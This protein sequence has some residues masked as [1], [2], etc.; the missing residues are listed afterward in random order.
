L[1]QLPRKEKDGFERKFALRASGEGKR[2]VNYLFFQETLQG[3]EGILTR[4][5]TRGPVVAGDG[6]INSSFGFG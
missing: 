2:I 5:K 6:G 1:V 4:G 3:K